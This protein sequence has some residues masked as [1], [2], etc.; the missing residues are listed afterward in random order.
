MDWKSRRVR[1][2]LEAALAEDKAAG[3]L[4]TAMTIDPKLCGVGTIIARSPCVVAGL[5][6]I[7]VV[8]DLFAAQ[9][10]K[11]GAPPAGRFEIV[12]HPEIFDGVKVR[13]N[14]PIAVIRHNAAALFA[15]ER[16]ILNLLQRMSGIASATRRYADA[17]AGTKTRILDTRKTTPGL[18]LVEKYAVNCGGGV[19]HRQD[20][21]DG[22][23]IRRSHIELGG[24]IAKTLRNAQRFGRG[25]QVIQ[26]ELRS[27]AEVEEAIAGKA[28]AFLLGAMTPTQCKR[29]LKDIRAAL[30][31]AT[32]GFTGA[33]SPEEARLY[34]LAGV[35]FIAV[36]GLT[37]EASSADLAMR[38]A[39]DAR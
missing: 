7:P 30:P 8:F 4:T 36:S 29:A 35:D 16:V 24:G 13:K 26:I 17:V 25:R 11:A 14:Q 6:A 3:D 2:V 37:Q 18:R 34:A 22:V 1:A 9:R 32:V 38:L 10:A 31:D 33:G 28:G 12:S 19:T 15:T 39:A 5:G 23:L 20:L 21:E 27:L